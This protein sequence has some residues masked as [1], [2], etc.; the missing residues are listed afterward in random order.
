MK[1][2]IKRWIDHKKYNISVYGWFY[3]FI[4]EPWE[5]WVEIPFGKS[6]EVAKWIPRLWNVRSWEGTDLLVVM[7]YQLKRM[8]QAQQEDEHHCEEH[9]ESILIGPKYAKIIQEARDCITRILEDEY[10]KEEKKAHDKK[11][12]KL[13]MVY[14]KTKKQVDDDYTEIT[15][16]PNGKAANNAR[17]KIYK[18]EE[19]RKQADYDKMFKIIKRDIEKWWT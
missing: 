7:D 12:G 1:K 15:F 2:K 3:A 13:E 16:K 4:G 10:C 8:Q 9:D 11:Y 14:G 5:D 6:V 19:K 18:L 17:G